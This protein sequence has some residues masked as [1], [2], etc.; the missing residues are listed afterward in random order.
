MGYEK[1]KQYLGVFL[2]WADIV[3]SKLILFTSLISMNLLQT[4]DKEIKMGNGSENTSAKDQ[5]GDKNEKQDF[6]QH[7]RSLLNKTK[8]IVLGI[9]LVVLITFIIIMVLVL[10]PRNDARK[11]SPSEFYITEPEAVTSCGPVRGKV[12][13]KNAMEFLGIPYALP[14]MGKHRFKVNYYVLCPL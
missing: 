6:Y 13:D 10:L 9:L 4:D 14:P 1:S 5:D 12:V 11:T 8:L 2:H 7:I 3:Y